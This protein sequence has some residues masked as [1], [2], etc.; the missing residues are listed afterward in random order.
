MTEAERRKDRFRG[1]LIGGAIGDALGYPIE[2]KK[3][4]E[5]E[6]TGFTEFE[7]GTGLISDDTQMTLFTAS[8]ILNYLA[9]KKEGETVSLIKG[10]I[11]PAY[12]RW[13]FT[14]TRGNC[15]EDLRVPNDFEKEGLI[16]SIMERRELFARRAPGSTCTLT[17]KPDEMGTFFN[18]PN[19]SKGCGGVMR[20]AP[21]GLSFDPVEA[22]E[23][24]ADAA[25]LTHFH[26]T[27]YSSAAAFALII[28][29]IVNCGASLTE[30]VNIAIRSGRQVYGAEDETASALEKAMD[31]SE[32]DLRPSRA[33]AKL[34]ANRI[35]GPGWTGEEALA[36]AV[37]CALKEP[38]IRKALLMAVNHDGD[39]DSTGAICGNIL[40]ALYGYE[41]L[42]EDWREK[43]ELSG[44]ILQM[45]DALCDAA[46]E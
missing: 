4:I 11:Y 22:M 44:F 8:G 38:D 26:R 5:A 20:V 24:A 37:Y 40:G 10:G 41:A 43:V 32:G 18:P 45:A 3:G 2:F 13:I 1:C 17:L 23:K 9:K 21:I 39:S 34:G 14:Q 30:A 36:V 31:L 15:P 16:P 12:K 46:T 33:I 27:G 25:A 35:K 7:G 6:V 42:P 19:D 28:S 29:E